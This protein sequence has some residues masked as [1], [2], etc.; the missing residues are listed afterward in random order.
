MMETCPK[1]NRWTRIERAD[2]STAERECPECPRAPR[3][4]FLHLPTG[5]VLTPAFIREDDGRIVSNG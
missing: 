4:R 3:R 1:H 2:G 5:R